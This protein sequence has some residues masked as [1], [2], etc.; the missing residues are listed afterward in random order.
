[1]HV[2]PQLL[3]HSSAELKHAVP[4]YL[5]SEL[6]NEQLLGRIFELDARS[7][8]LG[9]PLLGNDNVLSELIPYCGETLEKLHLANN[10]FTQLPNEIGHFTALQQLDM[11]GNAID[12]FTKDALEFPLTRLY[13]LNLSDNHLNSL[14]NAVVSWTALVELNVSHN[15]LSELPA[16]FGELKAL[17]VL[18]A[19]FN[20]L[21]KLP[22]SFSDLPSIV[23]ADFSFN[24][25]SELPGLLPISLHVLRV[26]HNDLNALPRAIGELTNLTTLYAD[27]NH[28]SK[29]PEQFSS[30]SGLVECYLQDNELVALCN[31]FGINFL[32]PDPDGDIMVSMF[33][34][35]PEMNATTI[36]KWREDARDGNITQKAQVGVAEKVACRKVGH[37]LNLEILDIADQ[38]NDSLQELPAAFDT[39][40]KLRSLRTSTMVSADSAAVL[41][42]GCTPNGKPV[43]LADEDNPIF[44]WEEAAA[45]KGDKLYYWNRLTRESSWTLP[46]YNGSPVEPMR[47][48]KPVIPTKAAFNESHKGKVVSLEPALVGSSVLYP[49]NE[50]GNLFQ[51]LWYGEAAESGTTATIVSVELR[52][53]GHVGLSDGTTFEN[54]EA[55]PEEEE[56]VRVPYNKA[57]LASW[58]Y[59]S[60]RPYAQLMELSGIKNPMVK[61]YDSQ[62]AQVDPKNYDLVLKAQL[63]SNWTEQERLGKGLKTGADK[64]DREERRFLGFDAFMKKEKKKKK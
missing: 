9:N 5:A 63:L 62:L 4:P 11:S 22:D 44:W 19:D 55:V 57:L 41:R 7:N 51:V 64:L 61:I 38:E 18:K 56:L 28:L 29:L 15:R 17:Q 32:I 23:K 16:A 27:N 12:R 35:K 47:G 13:R 21:T 14:T 42:S 8:K 33:N 46:K 52:F 24:R 60:E 58:F 54:P 53:G 40:V 37:L 25:L 30:M 59:N 36:W 31:S 3:P 43:A 39:L 6:E 20:A 48:G 45:P 2:P 34:G 1:M 26:S 49:A 50:S 10:Q